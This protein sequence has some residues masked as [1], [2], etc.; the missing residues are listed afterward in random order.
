MV[1]PHATSMKEWRNRKEAEFVGMFDFLTNLLNVPGYSANE[2]D[3]DIY[4]RVEARLKR[5]SEKAK[6]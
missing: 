2:H 1:K 5:Q 4:N 3:A 6:A